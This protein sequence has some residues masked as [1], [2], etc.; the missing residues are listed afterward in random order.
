M[1]QNPFIYSLISGVLFALATPSIGIWQISVVSLVP[2]LFAV[3]YQFSKGK[4]SI[5]RM[6]CLGFLFSYTYAFSWFYWI[7][8]LN[9]A[10]TFAAP[11]VYALVYSFFAPGIILALKA[12]LRRISLSLWIVCLWVSLEVLLSDVFLRIPSMAVGYAVWPFEQIIQVADITGVFGVSIW[13]VAV[14][15]LI[16]NMI[17]SGFRKSTP[18]FAATILITCFFVG[19]GSVKLYCKRDSAENSF[20]IDT[21]YTSFLSEDKGRDDL[22]EKIF[23]ILKDSTI[24]SIDSA[25]ITPDLVVWPETSVPVFL[26][27][28]GEKQFIERLIELAQNQRVPILIGALSFD[29]NGSKPIKKYNSAF[30]V[31]EQGFISQEYHKNILAP[32]TEANPFRDV[33]PESINGFFPSKLDAGNEPGLMYLL[34]KTKFGVVICYEIFFPNF[35]RRS[36][37]DNSGFIVNITNDNHAFGNIRA[38][39]KIPL[40]HLVFRAIENRKYL[41][42]SANW[43]YSLVISPEGKILKSSPIGSTGYLSSTIQPNY[44]GTFFS[45]HGFLFAKVLLSIT[46]VWAV[47]LTMR[48]R[49]NRTLPSSRK[50]RR[51]SCSDEGRR[52]HGDRK[53]YVRD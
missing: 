34:D 13:V 10:A 50:L 43:G 1:W 47:I 29:R 6:Y 32:F 24:Q 49:R 11:A 15:V 40:P 52:G 37:G 19:Y 22:K 44:N 42:R 48:V 17:K 5:C 51:T 53:L 38:A 45:K 27:F 41:V 4:S 2:F 28:V 9:W 14:N 23:A 30:L 39:Y 25:G 46:A 3:E 21:V 16:F 31:P 36:A 18:F 7:T 20:S 8:N 26:R 35:V 33:L 12:G